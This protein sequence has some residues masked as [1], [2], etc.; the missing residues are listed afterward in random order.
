MG[1]TKR[2]QTSNMS[3]RVPPHERTPNVATN[4]QKIAKASC[5]KQV[6]LF[7]IRLEIR[8][9]TCTA[10]DPSED[11]RG[12]H[13]LRTSCERKSL[14]QFEELQG[15]L[16]VFFHLLRRKWEEDP[17]KPQEDVRRRLESMNSCKGKSPIQLMEL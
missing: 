12:R 15:A 11:P 5:A 10:E 8:H 14:I 2:T 17:Q 9:F 3:W 4:K 7:G 16:K 6:K 13:V 1:R